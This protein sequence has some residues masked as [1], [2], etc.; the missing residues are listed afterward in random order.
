[1]IIVN[2]FSISSF[3][4]ALTLL[5]IG[6][7]A[8]SIKSESDS[9]QKVLFVVLLSILMVMKAPIFYA[10]IPA[11]IYLFFKDYRLF[12]NKKYIFFASLIFLNLLIMYIVP[13]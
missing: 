9:E 2:V 12:I 1:M 6:K 3:L 11:L 7:T 5:L 4:Y 8:L 13:V 10:V